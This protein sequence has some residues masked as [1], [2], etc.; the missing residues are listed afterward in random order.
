[1]YEAVRKFYRKSYRWTYRNGEN[2]GH[3]QPNST[4]LL[5]EFCIGTADSRVRH[6]ES[7]AVL[8]ASSILSQKFC[9]QSTDY[10]TLYIIQYRKISNHI[11]GFTKQEINWVRN[12]LIRSNFAWSKSLV[13]GL[14]RH[15]RR[16]STCLVAALCTILKW[17]TVVKKEPFRVTTEFAVN[18]W[19]K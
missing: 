9:P 16:T 2:N 4:Q 6:L 7:R 5:Q 19:R 11:L 3:Y 8:L 12:W 1:M 17:R 18:Q 10:K 15:V 14:V 13:C